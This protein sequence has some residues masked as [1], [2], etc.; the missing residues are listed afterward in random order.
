MSKRLILI[1]TLAFVVGIAYA[2]YAEV[3]NVKVGGD[4]TAIGLMRELDL[5]NNQGGTE[6]K[7]K[8]QDMLSIVRVKIDADL[9]D[10][11]ST[12]IRL[13][14]DRY[15]GSSERS[16]DNSD[17]D[18]DLAY[19]TLKEFLYSPATLT[20]GSQELRFGNG[21]IIGDPTTNNRRSGDSNI[22]II[23]ADLD[24][25]K[26]FDAVRLTLNY[27]PLVLDIVGAKV[28]EN[29]QNNEDD[30]NLYGINANYA[31]SKTTTLEA[32]W[33]EK[34]SQRKANLQNKP[35]R[36]DVLGGRV[37][38]QPIENLTYQLE[39]AYQLG[40]SVLSAT[41]V[42]NRRAWALETSLTYAMPNVRYSPSLTALYN[43]FS[44]RRGNDEKKDTAWNP[45]FEDQTAGNI[46][47]IQID[48]SNCHV[49]GVIASAKPMDDVKLIGEY[50]AYWWDKRYGDGQVVTSVR[51]D[52]L[53][54]KNKKFA[55]QEIDLKTVYDYT[56]D[57]QFSLMT[58][59]FLPGSSFDKA[60]DNTATEVI[61]SMKVTF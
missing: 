19:V 1:L 33:F 23:D 31:L 39:A 17:I 54:M 21:M 25:R 51:G 46:A 28:E 50:Y 5:N 45:M 34:H 55:G 18:L 2:A 60:N 59:I 61:G 13:I 24:M 15:W 49:A 29:E 27:D 11:V 47:N 7:D 26:A 36:I 44:G 12:T 22:A 10:N 14:N 6:S 38:T 8:Y 37:V 9:T 16:S 4:I 57:V 35:D 52:S 58:G 20:I 48:Q 40:K 42:A 43:Y 30:I 41:N 56:E 3:Q 53:T 32:Y